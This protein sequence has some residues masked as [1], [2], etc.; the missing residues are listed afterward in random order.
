MERLQSRTCRSRLNHAPHQHGG[1]G[2]AVATAALLALAE[3]AE[4][5]AASAAVVNLGEKV[6]PRAHRQR[7]PRP[8]VEA[9]VYDDLLVGRVVAGRQSD[10]PATGLIIVHSVTSTE[11]VKM[12]PCITSS[13]KNW[14]IARCYPTV[15]DVCPQQAFEISSE[16][17]A[18]RAARHGDPHGPK[19]PER[20]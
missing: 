10:W 11:R 6:R 16:R 18:T 3:V 13:P 12:R 20:L 14:S 4:A 5:R 7:Q 17:R 2:R 9:D 8:A 15:T 1:A 19:V